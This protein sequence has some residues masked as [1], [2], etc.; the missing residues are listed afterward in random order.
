MNSFHLPPSLLDSANSIPFPQLYK[1]ALALSDKP[2]LQAGKANWIACPPFKLMP[3]LPQRFAK[4]SI[5]PETTSRDPGG[6]CSY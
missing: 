6:N 3:G 4:R 1:V 2:R 5:Y